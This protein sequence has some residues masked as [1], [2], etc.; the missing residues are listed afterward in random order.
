MP[1]LHWV[2]KTHFE[3]VSSLSAGQSSPP[4]VPIE[5]HLPIG[6]GPGAFA[7]RKRRCPVERLGFG[8]LSAGGD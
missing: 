6:I 7:A 5:S 3:P 8:L 4:A 1:S 2:L